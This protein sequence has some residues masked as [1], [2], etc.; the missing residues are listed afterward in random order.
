MISILK[1]FWAIFSSLFLYHLRG[2]HLVWRAGLSWD[3]ASVM[4]ITGL[5]S[6]AEVKCLYERAQEASGQGVIVEIGSYR[7]LSTVALARGSMKGPR[8]P[9]YAVDP[10]GFFPSSGALPAKG[11]NFGPSDRAAFCRNVLFAGAA[12]MIHPIELPSKQAVAGWKQAISLLWIDGCHDYDS[13]RED[14]LSWSPFVLSG[15]WVAFHD[16]SDP[17]GGPG[18]VIQEAL[19][20][21][22]FHL[23]HIVKKVSVLCKT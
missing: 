3:F 2:L 15:G 13:V 22:R 6:R 21:G 17:A 20:D 7:G 5:M 10:H 4:A 23:I 1:S 9:V 11:E 18:R 16:S 12:Q 8:V 19:A 14:F